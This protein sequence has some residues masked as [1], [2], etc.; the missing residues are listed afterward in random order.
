[1]N[2]YDTYLQE[3]RKYGQEL[4]SVMANYLN[5]YMAFVNTAIELKNLD[6]ILGDYDV[7]RFSNFDLVQSVE[8][9]DSGKT[10]IAHTMYHDFDGHDHDYNTIHTDYARFNLWLEDK[11]K[12]KLDVMPYIDSK[13]DEALAH[14]K[15][16]ALDAKMRADAQLAKLAQT[17]KQEQTQQNEKT[18]GN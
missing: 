10:I 18:T 13:V 5:E 6:N 12:W 16:V 8:L 1:M 3:Q 14:A 4:C 15:A 9:S 17:D 2:I 11:E 7:L